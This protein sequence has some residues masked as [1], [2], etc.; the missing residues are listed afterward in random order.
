MK[1]FRA[2]WRWLLSWLVRYQIYETEAYLRDCE[3]EGLTSSLS[4]RDF[5]LQLSDLRVRLADL[6]TPAR[7]KGA[8]QPRDATPAAAQV[9]GRRHQQRYRELTMPTSPN[10][11]DRQCAPRT[12]IHLD[13]HRPV[14]V[15]RDPGD[16]TAIEAADRARRQ[17][18]PLGIDNQGRNPECAYDVAPAPAEAATEIGADVPRKPTDYERGNR[19][20][21]VVGYF[22]LALTIVGLCAWLALR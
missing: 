13:A 4:L 15:V 10:T 1:H 11:L 19:V 2:L 22:L 6:Q 20:G 3:R 17:Y 12:I 14:L 8:R 9:D 21:T 18:H 16:D 5:R 7:A